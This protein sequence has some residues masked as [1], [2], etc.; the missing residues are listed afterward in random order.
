[1][2]GALDNARYPLPDDVPTLAGWLSGAG[3]GTGAVVGSFVL[4]RKY[5]LDRGFDDYDDHFRSLPSGDAILIERSA[6]AVT[7]RAIDWLRGRVGGAPFLLWTHYYDPHAPYEPPPPFRARFA[8]DPYDGEVAYTDAEIG[9]LLDCVREF[10]LARNTLVVVVGDHGEAMGDGGERTHGL[11]LR[12]STLRVPLVLVAPHALP[13]GRHVSGV[14]SQVDIVPTILALLG[15]ET[16]G[17]LDGRS[18]LAMIGTGASEGR[19]AYSMTYLPRD[20]FG[21]ADLAGVRTDEWAWVRAPEPELYD[22]GRDPA[23]TRN[24]HGEHPAVVNRL[25]DWLEAVEARG[26]GRDAVAIDPGDEEALRALGY[27]MTT[28]TPERTGADPKSMLPIWNDTEDLRDLGTRGQWTE[29][30]RRAPPLLERAPENT[31]LVFLY[32]QALLHTGRDEEGLVYLRRAYEMTGSR[33]RAGTVL[34][35]VLVQLGREDEAIAMLEEFMEADPDYALHAYNL[36]VL[37]ATKGRDAE[38]ID[39]YEHALSIE[40]KSI[41]ILSNLAA[42]RARTGLDPQR[43][44]ELVDRAI[45]LSNDDDRPRLIRV[46]VLDALGRGDEALALATELANAPHLSGIGRKEVAEVLRGLR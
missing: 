20:Q 41:A 22:L 36:G 8:L 16:P 38:A 21:W 4:Q 11:L 43:A 37:H 27:A 1:A 33:V 13:S 10:G 2:H 35:R 46:T 14:V 40:P 15:E 42:A 29:I 26:V 17:D 30:A 32:G 3:Y 19:R 5:G 34:A 6:T 31:S 39:A 9:R 24:V 18:L 12:D 7:D 25:A 23:E 44:L 45:E 28:W